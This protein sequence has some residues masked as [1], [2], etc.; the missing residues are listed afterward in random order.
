[1]H[2]GDGAH[3]GVRRKNVGVFTPFELWKHGP[4]K[5]FRVWGQLIAC[6]VLPPGAKLPA[7]PTCR[8][9]PC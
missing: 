7:M 2:G 5:H 3:K 4:R 1:M 6:Q 8:Q 9:Q